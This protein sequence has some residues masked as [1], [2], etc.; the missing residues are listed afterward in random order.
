MPLVLFST[1]GN[2]LIL[3]QSIKIL[4]LTQSNFLGVIIDGAIIILVL[5]YIISL[6]LHMLCHVHH[7]E[8][9]LG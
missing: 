9:D 8:Y 3:V 2:I 1:T 4:I 7:R 5:P 6:L